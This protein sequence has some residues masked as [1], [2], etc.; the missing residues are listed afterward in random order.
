MRRRATV[1]L[2]PGF[3]GRVTQPILVRLAAR[4]T[5][6]GFDCRR[7]APPAARPTPG[8]EREVTWLGQELD[9]VRGRVA[10]VGRSFGGRV[11]ARLAERLDALVLLGFPVR[12]PGR[13][14]PL[15]EAALAAAPCPTLVV[16]GAKDPL[17]P[18]RVLRAVAAANRQLELRVLPGAGHAFGQQEAAALDEVAAWLDASLPRR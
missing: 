2:L 14:R 10:V 8:L 3:R 5:R 4:L 9:A 6:L 18:V 1:L 12:P 7:L 11:A 17:G 15:D 16:Q 13:R